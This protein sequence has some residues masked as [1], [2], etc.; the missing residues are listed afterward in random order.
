MGLTT[1]I[2]GGSKGIGYAL[3]DQ[4]A[5]RNHNLV[6][7]ARNQSPLQE[8]A[9]KLRSKYDIN[10]RVLAKDLSRQDAPR[11]LYEKVQ[12]EGIKVDWLIN[13]A[14]FG[15]AGRFD[16]QSLDRQRAMVQLNATTLME[17]THHL[18]QEMLQRDRGRIMN[19]AST[20]AFQPGP[21]MALYYATKSFVL[22]LSDAIHQELVDTNVTISTLC[23]GPTS[24]NFHERAGTSGRIIN[25]S[26]L[27]M[28]PERVAKAGIEGLEKGKS[29]IVPG[30]MN[31]AGA[32]AIQ[33]VPRSILRKIVD[34]LH[35]ST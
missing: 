15:G 20:A 7:V 14:G 19:V 33:F 18:L 10:C 23:P 21:N 27:S 32:I 16:Q 34:Y 35:S 29:V 30:F 28:S 2:T 13:N 3:A 6:L 17:L 5:Q 1:L 31:K 24:T 9:D 4:L 12:A 26:F 25:N 11:D 22:S 8:A